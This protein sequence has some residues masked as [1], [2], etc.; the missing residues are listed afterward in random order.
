MKYRG[1]GGGVVGA[2]TRGRKP[3]GSAAGSAAGELS[4][5]NWE[6][7]GVCG[8]QGRFMLL[9][10]NSYVVPKEK[11]AEHARLVRKFRQTLARLGCDQFDV[12]EQ[13]GPNWGG[14][15]TT[16]RFVQMMRFRDRKHQVAVQT[17]E[18]QDPAAQALIQEFCDLINFGYQQQQGLFAV[19]YYQSVLPVAPMRMLPVEGEEN[20]PPAEESAPASASSAE[21]DS[22]DADVD[23]GIEDD[24]NNNAD[25]TTGGRPA[26]TD[27]KLGPDDLEL[28][29]DFSDLSNDS[30]GGG[31]HP[32]PPQA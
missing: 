11:R 4:L 23:M 18:K 31:E 24:V 10:T 26:Q 3:S 29:V 12:F 13:V 6:F 20:L 17:A 5:R 19:G 2:R 32:R 16:G 30:G 21:A 27:D 22:F 9:Q 7:T 8:K 1:G 25:A 28:E 14:G 15:E